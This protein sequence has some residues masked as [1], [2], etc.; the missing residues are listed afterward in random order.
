MKSPT[1]GLAEL[2]VPAMSELIRNRSVSPVDV[3][4]S[5]LARIERINPKIN[6]FVE[7]DVEGALAAARAAEAAVMR[8]DTLGP[9]HGIPVTIK[10]IQTVKGSPTRRGSRLTPAEPA[11][12]DAPV[13]ARLRAAGAVILGK[14]TL[15]EHGWTAVSDSP[16]TGATHNPWHLGVTS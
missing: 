13:V 3:V 15:S 11:A 9:L 16:L 14:T 7:L 12:A 2:P 5:I 1:S 6:A 10:D 8:G 4:Q